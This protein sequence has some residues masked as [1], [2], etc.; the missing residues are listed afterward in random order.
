MKILVDRLSP[1]PEEFEFEGGSGWWQHA[2]SPDAG[3]PSELPEPLRFRVRAYMAADDVILEGTVEG[4]IPL[5]CSRCLARYRHP[6][7]E[8]FRLVLEP[9][10]SRQPA[11]PEAAQALARDG[12]C[13]GEDVESGWFRGDEIDMGPFFQELV[14]LSLPVKPLC[15]EDCKGLCSRCGADL[16]E[17]SCACPEIEKESP[18]AVLRQLRDGLVRGED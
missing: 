16:N 17:G 10:G 5:E 13:L 4:T 11:D 9:A 12:M 18:F 14:S 7:H 1:T 8:S 15:R 6:L 3:L 2:V